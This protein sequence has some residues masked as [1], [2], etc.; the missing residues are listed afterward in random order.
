MSPE[1]FTPDIDS[2]EQW[3]QSSEAS[4]EVS[5]KFKEAVKRAWAKIKKTQKDEKKAKKYDFL[6]A[7]I[8]VKIIV[9]KK[10]DFILDSLFKCLHELFPSN[11]ILWILSL[12]NINISHKIREFSNK[13][14][15]SFNFK[16]K[17][18][19]EFDDNKLN[20]EVKNRINIWV[21]DMIDSVSIEYSSIQTEKL[22]ELLSDQKNILLDY[23]SKVFTFF[24][25]EINIIIDE[26]KAI[27]ISEFILGEVEKSLKNL[28]IEEI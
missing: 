21:E 2:S 16:E 15:I 20:S 8:L 19:I 12:I 28:E 27:N 9:D 18:I 4:K 23:T 7:W 5:E 24:L 17:E 10:Y 14:T 26:S 22:I 6:L 1:D 25:K 11:F 13:D 3:W